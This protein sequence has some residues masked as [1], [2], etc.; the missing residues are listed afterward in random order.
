MFFKYANLPSDKMPP[1][2]LQQKKILL[3]SDADKFPIFLHYY[4]FCDI[5]L[6]AF[7]H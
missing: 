1:K 5:F 3:N 4:Y 7:P 2:K 6:K